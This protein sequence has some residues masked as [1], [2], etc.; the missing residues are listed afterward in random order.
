MGTV[1]DQGRRVPGDGTAGREPAL[2][3]SHVSKSFQ[4]RGESSEVVNDASLTVEANELVSIVGPSGCGKSTLLRIIAGLVSASSG[5]VT[6][7]GTD[8][9]DSLH[10]LVLVFQEYER[11]LCPWRSAI[12]NVRLGLEGLRL[13]R[14]E[15]E[16]RADA[17][18]ASVGL[19]EFAEH[20][21]WELSGGMQQ[22]LQIARALAFQPSILL[23]DE[24]F[25]ALDALTRYDL[26]DELLRLWRARSGMSIVLVT[27]DIDEAI[28]LSD[29]V[30]VVSSRPASVL[31]E[32]TV[33]V[34]RPRDQVTSRN[35][36]EFQR[37]RAEIVQL[38]GR[39]SNSAA[40]HGADHR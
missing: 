17:A 8:S 33:D 30:L 16:E 28:Y 2:V 9:K 27:H 39:T 20:Y 21:P 25:G 34:P 7:G 18:L 24:P 36:S 32:F 35:S 23:M 22:R 1:A 31:A 10:E 37:L 38:I 26:E 3:V 14:A 5:T 19:Q 4:R 6:V 11:S 29:R 13:S 40:G 12:G 15:R